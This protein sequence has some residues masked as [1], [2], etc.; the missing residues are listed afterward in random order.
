MPDQA[1]RLTLY[2]RADCPLCDEAKAA[3]RRA[4]DELGDRFE[5]N[6]VD[7]EGDARLTELYG[8]LI[9]VVTCG[10]ETLFVGKVSLHR[11]KAMI[12]SPGGPKAAV[13]PRYWTFLERLKERLK[14]AR[15]GES[16]S[17]CPH[18]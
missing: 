7:I 14:L 9:P 4:R 17:S 12:E 1:L 10:D 15:A 18:K 2:T 16:D 5:F 11:L 3:L 8:Q 6:E 13:G